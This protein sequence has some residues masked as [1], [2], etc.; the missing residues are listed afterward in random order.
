MN[1]LLSNL[2]CFYLKIRYL[3][4]KNYLTKKDFSD[5]NLVFSDE[6]QTLDNFDKVD[7]EFYNDNPVWF[8]KDTIYLTS[9]GVLIKCYEDIKT[10]TSWQGTRDCTHT[11]GMI[12]TRNKFLLKNGVWVVNANACESWCA[13]W[14]LKK[15]RIE[16]GYTKQQI[17]PEIDILEILFKR[18][19]AKHGIVYGYSDIKY[20]TKG[21]GTRG[22]VKCDNKFHEYAVEFLSNGYK[23]YID[24]ILTGKFIS[25]DPEFVSDCPNYLLLNNA[26]D[27][28]TTKNTEFIVKSVK[29][30]E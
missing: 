11:S 6:F 9:E 14:L 23:F 20:A 8:S 21:I 12:H 28:Y 29:V 22:I 27:S 17:T 24:G 10:H 16:P 1:N 25:D 7:K 13:I 15:D 4:F 26:S 3:L 30:Y 18:N 5:R 2:E 19:Q